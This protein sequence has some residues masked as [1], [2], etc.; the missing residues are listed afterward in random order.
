MQL[1]SYTKPS[2]LTTNKPT[3]HGMVSNLSQLAL[4]QENIQ[5]LSYKQQALHYKKSSLL[6]IHH[7]L[8]RSHTARNNLNNLLNYSRQYYFTMGCINVLVQ[9][10]LGFMI[11]SMMTPSRAVPITASDEQRNIEVEHLESVSGGVGMMLRVALKSLCTESIHDCLNIQ[12]C[13]YKYSA[14]I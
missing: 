12:V 1:L 3:L 2:C 11:L 10:F 14:C 8:T 7:Q 5:L 13:L 9:A 4:L 6:H